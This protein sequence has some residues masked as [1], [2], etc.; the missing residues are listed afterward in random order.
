MNAVSGA[1]RKLLSGEDLGYDEARDAMDS[2]MSGECSQVLMA[3]YL[4]A[5]EVKGETVEEIAASASEMRAHALRLPGDHTDALEIVGTG[6]DMT[7]TFNISTTSAF[8]IAACGVPVAKHGNRAMSSK[9]GAADVL[10]ALGAYLDIEPE[11]SARILEECGF[12]FMFAQKYHTSMRYVAPVRKELGFRTVFNIL[13][14]LTNPAFAGNQF[15][16]VYSEDLVDTVA[17]VLDR[18][19]VRNALVVHGR[20]GMDE[21]TVCDETS[22]CEVR[23]GSFERYVLSPEEFG[24]DRSPKDS[25][26][27]GGPEENAAITRSVL[28]G[29]KGPR[30]DAVLMNAGAGLYTAGKAKTIAE[31]I[32]MAENAIDSGEALR[33]LDMFVRMT[34]DA[35]ADRSG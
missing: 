18:M 2:M 6:G 20:D 19:G 17:R 23:H 5:L 13:G 12:A 10:E 32:E 35:H 21:I 15:T 31:G 25:L 26:V 29:S 30:R 9:S 8:A 24:F 7:G 14:P 33:R 3:S 34:G 11:D 16:G 4:T 28:S 22:C 1:V 27:G